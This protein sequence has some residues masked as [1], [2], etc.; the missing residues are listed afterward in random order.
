[1]N[2]VPIHSGLDGVKEKEMVRGEGVAIFL[3]AMGGP[4]TQ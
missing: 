3:A 2:E 1:M 4:C